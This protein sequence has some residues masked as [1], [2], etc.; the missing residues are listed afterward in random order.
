MARPDRCRD[1]GQP[2]VGHRQPP[3]GLRLPLRAD[4]RHRL[5]IGV[6]MQLVFVP[7]LYWLLPFIDRASVSE[8]AEKLTDRA[9]RLGRAPAVPPGRDRRAHRRGALLP[10][11]RAR[12]LQARWSDSL[13]LVA[14]SILF[15]LVHFQLLTAPGADHVRPR[16]RLLRPAH[17]AP[18]H[19][20]LRP[21]RLQRHHRRRPAA[22]PL[23]GFTA[24]N[25]PRRR[26]NGGACHDGASHD[27]RS[28]PWRSPARRRAAARSP[29]R[30]GR[31]TATVALAE[32]GRRP[33]AAWTIA[34]S[35]IVVGGCVLFTLLQLHPDLLFNDTTPTG[36]DMGA[37]VWGPAYLRDHLLPAL[38]AHRLGAPT[39]TPASPCTVFYMVPPA[40]MVVAA[41][42]RPA[43]RRGPQDRQ[44]PRHPDPAG[45][46]LGRSASSPGCA[47]PIPQ[48]FA[49]AAVVFLFDE[50][51]QIYGG[52]IAS[53]MAGEFSFSIALSLA[54]LFFGVFAY[55]HAHR[56]ATAPWPPVLFAL[57]G[58][59]PR[60]RH[61]LRRRR[62]RGACS[63]CGPTAKRL[64]YA[65]VGRRSSAALL[66][67]FWVVP[68]C[69]QPPYMTDMFYERHQPTTGRCS[70][71]SR[72]STGAVSS[73]VLAAG[74]AGRRRSLRGMP[75]RAPSSASCA[76]GYGVWACLSAPEPPLEHAAAAVLVPDCVP[77]RRRRARGARRRAVIAR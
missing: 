33:P 6:L 66:C 2:P 55:G 53:T 58:P 36:G 4:R 27:R 41:R 7:V 49:V 14:T 13:A 11:P 64:R 48:L 52:N 32:R 71:R 69:A 30:G 16:R 76:I 65:A 37:H 17:Q 51:F 57:A 21:R 47:F 43:L 77:A 35:L 63:C 29:R 28:R 60:H 75:R 72:P 67:A 10:R 34:T 42:P 70:S 73:I 5:P 23:R 3:E 74:R 56:Q 20:D 19:V 1:R 38:P 25:V 61:V 50:S 68:F 45:L 12:S 24:C 15:G 18:R 8:S 59:V 40:L 26:G 62:R 46:L 22:L 54:M 9:D 39:G 31:R 44:R